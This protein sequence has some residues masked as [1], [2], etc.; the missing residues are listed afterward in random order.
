MCELSGNV[1]RD[2]IDNSTKSSQK[3]QQVESSSVHIEE[4]FYESLAVG[5]VVE[6]QQEFNCSRVDE[7][8]IDAVWQLSEKTVE[9]RFAEDFELFGDF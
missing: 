5:L 3:W 7:L 9:M 1:G 6:A 4:S 8:T 2:E